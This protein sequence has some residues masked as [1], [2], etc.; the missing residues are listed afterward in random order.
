V[1][2]VTTSTGGVFCATFEAQETVTP[3]TLALIYDGN[4]HTDPSTIHIDLDAS[5]RVPEIE[6]L[7][8]QRRIDVAGTV[9][10]DF[11]LRIGNWPVAHQP[12]SIVLTSLQHGNGAPVRATEVTNDDGR[13]R[14][15][16]GDNE[17]RTAGAGTLEADFS[18]NAQIPPTRRTW[19][20]VRVCNVALQ[21]EELRPELA[22]G[23]HAVLT[24]TATTSCNTPMRGI[25][26][27][28]GTGLT[29]CQVHLVNRRAT[30]SLNTGQLREGPLTIVASFI[31]PSDAWTSTQPAHFPMVIAPPKRTAALVWLFATAVILAWLLAKWR[32]AVSVRLPSSH[33]KTRTL[34][35]SSIEYAPPEPGK[36]G[37]YGVIIDAHTGAR[38]SG[39]NLKVE[40]PGFGEGS[41][42]SETTS[43]SNGEFALPE[44]ERRELSRIVAV[45]VHYTAGRWP[46]PSPGR[47][48]IRLQTYRR[49]ILQTFVSWL[50]LRTGPQPVEP[51]PALV[52]NDTGAAYA[53]DVIDWARNVERAAFGPDE[54][55]RL[56][57]SL[58]SGPPT[59]HLPKQN[60]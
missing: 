47:L 32:S 23:D 3:L 55:D 35:A 39:A 8:Q 36:S 48:T 42:F 37:W 19:P 5:R 10:F 2:S 57:E 34:A 58:V 18:G 9:S 6:W 30:C 31:P 22:R 49:A 38:I 44:F 43:D 33:G 15:R 28:V 40:V 53:P 59:R 52:A 12:L 13:A 14:F 56:G 60:D 16:V 51:T 46:L 11:R 17:L 1:L 54:S 21:P 24:V 7:D 20:I 4:E 50:R 41:V 29:L 45:A 25:V 26:E 27:F